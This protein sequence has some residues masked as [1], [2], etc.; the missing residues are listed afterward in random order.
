MSS[1]FRHC[2][3]FLLGLSLSGCGF[4]LEG[5]ATVPAPLQGATVEG[6]GPQGASLAE[7]V[8]RELERD[9]NT[10]SSTGPVI[11]VNSAGISQRIISIS[12]TSGAA[13]EFLNTLR[14]VVSVTR[15]RTLMLPPQP[16]FVEQSFTYNSANPLATT[17]QQMENQRQILKDGANSILNRIFSVPQVRQH[18]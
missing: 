7:A 12:P 10:P 9:G 2:A 17:V 5:G 3:I 4:H 1:L 15:G 14:A 16:L 8:R 13:L 11:H 6:S 18:S